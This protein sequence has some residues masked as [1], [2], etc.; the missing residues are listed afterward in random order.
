MPEV[1]VIT[2]IDVDEYVDVDIEY[3][4]GYC[5]DEEIKT[6][7]K[8]LKT[9]EY[10][11]KED[12]VSHDLSYSEENFYKSVEKLSGLYYSL[13]SDDCEALDRILKKY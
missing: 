11:K 2:T 1:N 5:S 12:I 10:I 4:L 9:N 8:W 3:I 7:I 6:V 13:T